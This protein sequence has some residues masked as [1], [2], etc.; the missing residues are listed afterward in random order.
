MQI[1]SDTSIPVEGRLI[2]YMLQDRQQTTIEDIAQILECS[3]RTAYRHVAKL[4]NR[5]HK[6]GTFYFLSLSKMSPVVVFNISKDLNNK[7]QDQNQETTTTNMD[8][9]YSQDTIDKITAILDK[10]GKRVLLQEVLQRLP[11]PNPD[12]FEYIL[13]DIVRKQ[14]QGYII[15]NFVGYLYACI[16]RMWTQAVCAVEQSRGESGQYVVPMDVLSDTNVP[17]EPEYQNVEGWSDLKQLL[18]S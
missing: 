15:H 7:T 4:G 1:Y 12:A 3:I 16:E 10:Y 17:I 5:I 2:I 11:Q 18:N 8:S 6:S 13:K 14:K 9:A